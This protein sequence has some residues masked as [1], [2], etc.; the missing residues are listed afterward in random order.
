[1][2]ITAAQLEQRKKHVGSSDMAAVL[3]LSP[4]KSAWD[5]WVDKTGKLQPEREAPNAAAHAGN[6]FERGVLSFARQELGKLIRNQYRAAAEFHLG[7]N[8]DALAVER[9]NQPVEAKTAGLFGPLR[10]E[11][12]ESGTDQVPDLYIIQAHV[13]MICA[14]RDLCHLAAFLG[15][16]GFTLYA[17]PLVPELAE[18][19]KCRAVEFWENHVVRDIPPAESWPSLDVAKRIRRQPKKVVRIPAGLVAGWQQIAE[20]RRE[21]EDAEKMAKSFI[22]AALGDAEAGV[23]ETGEAVTYFVESKREFTVKAHSGPVLRHKKKGLPV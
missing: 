15:G 18:I 6:L 9:E 11:W 1:M 13:H 3:G 4:W 17:I 10:G 23:T 19:I 5:V 20:T 7:A 12:G 2:T 8:I 21:A 14:E 22:L 16:R